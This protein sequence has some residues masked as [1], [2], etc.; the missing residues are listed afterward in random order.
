M[1]NKWI[2]ITFDSPYLKLGPF[3]FR[4][5]GQSSVKI[6]VIYVDN[7]IRLGRGSRGS[8]FI[9]KRCGL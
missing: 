5:G 1:D 9:F 7:K 4:Y 6:A 2:Q 3:E 8:I